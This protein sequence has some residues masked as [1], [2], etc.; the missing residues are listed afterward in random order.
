MQTLEQWLARS[1]SGR[2]PK[3]PIPKVS[4]KMRRKLSVYRVK[5]ERYL[6]END[7]C[8]VGPVLWNADILESNCSYSATEVHHKK[9]RLGENLNDEATWIATCPECH[10][11]VETHASTA[12]RLG[13]L[14]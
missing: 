1:K 2:K 13:L 12:R 14:Y 5:R 8:E 4:S 10:R 11:Y 9:R 7:R 6:G 3:K